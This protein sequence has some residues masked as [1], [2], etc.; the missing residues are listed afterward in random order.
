MNPF[1]IE[2]GIELD[3]TMYLPYLPEASSYTALY[4]QID[5]FMI[6]VAAAFHESELTVDSPVD[7][8]FASQFPAG[9][10]S[11]RVINANMSFLISGMSSL[12]EFEESGLFWDMVPT[13]IFAG[14]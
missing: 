9:E 5:D 4:M 1:E 6:P 12:E 7:F 3:Q 13:T 2:F 11:F 8:Y 14:S 10:Y